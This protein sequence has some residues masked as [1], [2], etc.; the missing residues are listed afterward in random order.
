[1]LTS[2]SNKIP[3]NTTTHA[4]I[5]VIENDVHYQT[6]DDHDG[7][8]ILQDCINTKKRTPEEDKQN[9]AGEQLET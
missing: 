1:M 2:S 7:P 4:S 3:Y 8:Q 9:T 5:R 6:N